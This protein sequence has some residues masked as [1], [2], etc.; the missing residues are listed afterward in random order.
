MFGTFVLCV[1]CAHFM[2]IHGHVYKKK[3]STL[4][5]LERAVICEY[6]R[7]VVSLVRYNIYQRIALE[8]YYAVS[9]FCIV[10]F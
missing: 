6:V 8:L 9:V 1:C 5:S 2:I 4:Y 7:F 3:N 10:G